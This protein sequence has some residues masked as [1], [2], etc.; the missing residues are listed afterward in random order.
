[1]T[2]LL[3][4][5]VYFCKNNIKFSKNFPTSHENIPLFPTTVKNVSTHSASTH[6]T[7]NNYTC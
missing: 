3:Q 7:V 5:I 1:M 2:P 4:V 6:L